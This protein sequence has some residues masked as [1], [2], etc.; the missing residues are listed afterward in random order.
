MRG[1]RP[2]PFTSGGGHDG[3]PA[4]P[5]P[6]PPPRWPFLTRRCRS[7]TDTN[8]SCS[9]QP[10]VA[11]PALGTCSFAGSLRLRSSWQPR[12]PRRPTQRRLPARQRRARV[13]GRAPASPAPRRAR[14]R[15]RRAVGACDACGVAGRGAERGRAGLSGAGGAAPA[16]ECGSALAADVLLGG[17]RAAAGTRVAGGPE[18]P[19]RARA[20]SGRRP[21][22][23]GPPAGRGPPP[24]SWRQR[25]RGPREGK[26]LCSGC[27]PSFPGPR[28]APAWLG[29]V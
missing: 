5:R 9:R 18:V 25:T 8:S 3:A 22:P 1:E 29:S 20:G 27:F 4:T 13:R 28:S 11:P 16:G 14:V 26:G 17:L 7:D 10:A 12:A 19:G 2:C 15:D 6:G 23:S 24:V 21:G